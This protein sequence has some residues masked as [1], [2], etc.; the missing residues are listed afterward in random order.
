MKLTLS[1]SDKVAII[2]KED[3][4]L[5]FYN[6]H[7]NWSGYPEAWIPERKKKYTLHRM[8]MLHQ[9]IVSD[10]H[11]PI[12]HLNNNP[13]DNRRENLRLSSKTENQLRAN[14]GGV[15]WNKEVNKWHV[16]IKYQK[17]TIHLGNFSDKE[18]AETLA[19]LARKQLLQL[20]AKTENLEPLTV[21]SYFSKRK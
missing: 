7:L 11:S 5:L 6:W 14:R 4:C 19:L 18:L 12:E 21:K 8:V 3:A 20:I 9:D 1:N 13:L 10:K 2:S 15:Y 17:I 16:Q